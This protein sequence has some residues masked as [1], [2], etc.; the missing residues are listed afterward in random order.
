[1]GRRS[2]GQ[3]GKR[4]RNVAAARIEAGAKANIIVPRLLA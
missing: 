1:M 3:A 2:G 4:C